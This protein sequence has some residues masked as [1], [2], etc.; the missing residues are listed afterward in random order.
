MSDLP[1]VPDI[2]T[3]SAEPLNNV[4]AVTSVAVALIALL[5]SFGLP[6]N[7]NQQSA[8]LGAVAVIAPIVTALWGRMKVYSP[9]TVAKLLAAR[10]PTTGTATGPT[11]I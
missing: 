8:I 10:P 4:A 7:D 11:I 3:A 1:P 5:V 2:R 6:V 9:K